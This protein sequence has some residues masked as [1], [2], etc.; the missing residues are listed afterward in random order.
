MSPYSTIT[1]IYNPN[2]TGPSKRLA[3]ATRLELREALPDQQ[4]FLVATE[5]A[6]HAEQ[7]AF[8]L[9]LAS[10]KP[11][12]ISSSGDGGYNEVVNGIMR[13]QAKGANAT[14]GLLPGGN[15]NDHYHSVHTGKFVDSVQHGTEQAI[16]VLKLSSADTVRYAHSYIG[17][18]L[19]ANIGHKLTEA[20]LNRVNEAWIVLT[21]LLQFRT[22]TVTVGQKTARFHSLIFT[23]IG[24]MAKIFTIAGDTSITDGKF[25]M[26]FLPLQRKLT[27]AFSLLKAS[28]RGLYDTRQADNFTLTTNKPTKVQLDGEVMTIKKGARIDISMEHQV[29]RCI[30]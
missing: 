14:S 11:L 5:Y 28:A 30:I 17:L 8:E 22:T 21:S 26:H 12:I 18:G 15:A 25:E 7:L 1:I 27:L 4:V 24:R 6:G 10:K 9:A 3:E 13:A 23:N 19:T 29:L 2:S 16:D 20:N